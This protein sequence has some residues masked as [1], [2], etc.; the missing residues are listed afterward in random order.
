MGVVRPE[1]DLVQNGAAGS[2]ETTVAVTMSILG[3]MRTVETVEE[4]RLNYEV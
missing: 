1:F 4:S 3:L 2:L